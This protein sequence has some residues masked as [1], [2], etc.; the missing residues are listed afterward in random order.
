MIEQLW[1]PDT[2]DGLETSSTS[3]C[4]AL[5][6]SPGLATLPLVRSSLRTV[7][8]L[9]GCR[10]GGEEVASSETHD[11]VACFMAVDSHQ[12]APHEASMLSIFVLFLETFFLF[13]FSKWSPFGNAS[14]NSEFGVK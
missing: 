3:S 2:Y 14:Q 12:T 7:P 10:Q 4:D 9:L 13:L 5:L 11:A 1:G 8:A 6:S